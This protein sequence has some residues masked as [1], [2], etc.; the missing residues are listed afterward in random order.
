M[1]SDEYALIRRFFQNLTAARG[2]VLHGIGDD[3]AVLAV[4]PGHEL[5]VSTDTLV[6]GV[7]FP[8][9]TL[10]ADIGFKSMA[11]NLSDL[12]AMGA[13]PR[14]ATLA[15]TMPDADPGFLEL[16][17]HG[18]AESAQAHGVALVGG[19]LTRG[20][21]SITVQMMGTVPAGS[22]LLR[23]G[24]RPGEQIWVTGEL[25]SAALGLEVLQGRHAGK[26]PGVDACVLRLNRPE[27]RVQ[28]GLL[29]RGVASA[30][31]DISDGLLTD[32]NHLLRASGVGARI[33][34]A[35]IPLAPAV[36]ALVDLERRWQLALGGG[37]DYELCFT[38]PVAAAAKIGSRLENCGCKGTQIGSIAA[39]SGASWINLDGKRVDF[40]TQSGYQHF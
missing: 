2:D 12:A 17:C 34:L 16:F 28:A 39:G 30:A 19:D 37:D 27:P 32:L 26:G 31:I 21:L 15:L 35:R 5:I 18:F 10:P 24:A 14:W 13:E 3:A 7:H 23:S 4:P 38:A 20:P 8:V 1:S 33:D 9:A 22:A 11:V 25:G 36:A 29:L 40:S 6:C